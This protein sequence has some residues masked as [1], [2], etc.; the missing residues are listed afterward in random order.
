[1]KQ[2][3]KGRNWHFG[4]K[5]H[6]GTDQRGIVHTVKATAASVADITQL[7]DLLHGHRS[8]DNCSRQGPGV[9]C[10]ALWRSSPDQL[11]LDL[12]ALNPLVITT[13]AN[14]SVTP[15]CADLP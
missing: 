4:M 15:T 14:R 8:A 5:L 7:P 3:R 1:M 13:S 11:S 6:I 10:E 2:T 12:R 9:R